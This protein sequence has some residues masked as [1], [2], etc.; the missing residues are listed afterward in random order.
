MATDPLARLDSLVRTQRAALIAIARSE[1]IDA[2]DALECVQDALCTFLERDGGDEHAV[3]S[4]KTIVRNAARNRRRRHYRR[5]PHDEL[6]SH[7]LHAAEVGSDEVLARAE[8]VVRL[9]ACVA[10]L[11]AVQ[12]EVVMLR[13][14]EERPGEDVASLLGLTRG[15]VDVLVHRAKQA[16]RACMTR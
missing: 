16:L 5:T 6:E 11:C 8:D 2:Q 1:G 4:L 7:D 15:H 14:L 3:A 9:R 12:R 13:L 10:E